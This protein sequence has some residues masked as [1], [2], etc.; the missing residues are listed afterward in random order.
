ML[1]L[2][3]SAVWLCTCIVTV[4]GDRLGRFHSRPTGLP[5]PIEVDGSCNYPSGTVVLWQQ[6]VRWQQLDGE[7][8]IIGGSNC[9]VECVKAA[10]S[11]QCAQRADGVLIEVGYS[12][13]FPSWFWPKRQILFGFSMEAT[14]NFVWQD[15]TWLKLAGYDISALT[16]PLADVFITY[17]RLDDFA[18]LQQKELPS[19]EERKNAAAF[20]ATQCTG[21]YRNLI[22]SKLAALGVPIDSLGSCVPSGSKGNTNNNFSFSKLEALKSYRVYLA[23]EN[24]EESGYVS[25]KVMDGFLA[26][27]LPVYF[28]APDI[29]N[30]VPPKSLI[31]LSSAD[32]DAVFDKAVAMIKA[33]L[34]SKD[35]WESM[36]RWKSTSISDWTNREGLNL[37]QHWNSPKL[38]GSNEC[39]LCQALHDR[40]KHPQ[41]KLVRPAVQF[42]SIVSALALVIYCVSCVLARCSNGAKI[43]KSRQDLDCGQDTLR[44]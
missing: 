1:F 13:A 29:W 21:K 23:F 10:S 34:E 38:N 16:N 8:G 15:L 9:D 24:C 33:A 27:A 36:M 44:S 32:D 37:K 26:G 42:I 17:F 40:I 43:M 28:G 18:A 14:R 6:L 5:E 25:E 12:S 30:F 7:H 2:A 35:A 3:R 11:E 19:W 31:Q 41:L 4:E 39:R 20:V 22:V